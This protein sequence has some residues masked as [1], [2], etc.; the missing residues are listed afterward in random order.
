MSDSA[1]TAETMS[2]FL[3]KLRAM[4][5]ADLSV[6]EACVTKSGSVMVTT[7]GS[8]NHKL[9]SEMEKLG[10]LERRQEPPLPIE[11][12]LALFMGLPSTDRRQFRRFLRN[13]EKLRP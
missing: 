3:Q 13:Y 4:S 6:L 12:S 11:M 9:W 5:P 10:W 2:I 7:E 1:P 8:A